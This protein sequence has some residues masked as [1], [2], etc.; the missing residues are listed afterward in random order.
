M[1]RFLP[2]V[3]LLSL[4]LAG[5][6]GAETLH[7]PLLSVPFTGRSME[8]ATVVHITDGDTIRVEFEGCP[9]E[10]V[11]LRYIGMDTPERG[12]LAP[13]STARHSRRRSIG[14]S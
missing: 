10:D 13:S 1:R 14:R 5:V 12:V 7:L 2:V 9:L 8:W 4:V 3:L 6:S 11:R